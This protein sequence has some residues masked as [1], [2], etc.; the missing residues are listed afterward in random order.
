MGLPSCDL[1]ADA[2]SGYGAGRH[3]R[4]LHYASVGGV[5][6]EAWLLDHCL[7]TGHRMFVQDSSDE[8]CVALLEVDN[9]GG[10]GSGTIQALSVSGLLYGHNM[11]FCADSAIARV[12]PACTYVNKALLR[13]YHLTRNN[14]TIP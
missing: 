5:P 11:V 4:F 9:G 13:V 6:D 3:A 12:P 14:L 7:L 8:D 10:G 1:T 2:Q